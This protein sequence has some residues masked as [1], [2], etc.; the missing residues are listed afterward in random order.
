[1]ILDGSADEGRFR[2]PHW[3][4]KQSE[5]ELLLQASERTQFPVLRTALGLTGLFDRNSPDSLEIEEHFIAT[6]IV[7]CFRGAD[8]DSPVAKFQRVVSLLQK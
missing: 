3:F 6:C 2:L 7:E 5:W 1:M 8:G 4:L